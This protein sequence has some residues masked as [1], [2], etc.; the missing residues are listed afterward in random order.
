MTIEWIKYEKS[1]ALLIGGGRFGSRYQ[2]GD[3]VK[4]SFGF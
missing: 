4:A 1:K 2:S 3:C